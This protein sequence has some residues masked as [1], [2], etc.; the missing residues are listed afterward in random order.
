MVEHF[1]DYRTARIF[2]LVKTF[3]NFP[4]SGHFTKVSTAK[5]S[6]S[7]VA[8]LSMGVS[9]SLPTICKNF[10][11]EN[12][13]FSNLQKFS[14][15]KDSRY[16]VILVVCACVHVCKRGPAWPCLE[17]DRTTGCSSTHRASRLDLGCPHTK[18]VRT[19]SAPVSSS[20]PDSQS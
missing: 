7:T 12:S 5:F 1:E 16:T 10:N 20:L 11:H 18:V 4:V 13:P 14:P 3:A 15:T 6:L 9:L 8:L 2:L 19:G 17:M